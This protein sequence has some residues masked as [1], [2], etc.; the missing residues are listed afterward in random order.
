MK[1]VSF[2]FANI[3]YNNFFSMKWAFIERLFRTILETFLVVQMK[4]LYVS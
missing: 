2:F 4:G 1:K 3:I